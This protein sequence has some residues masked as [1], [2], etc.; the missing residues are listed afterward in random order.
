MNES[1]VHTLVGAYALDAVDDLERARFDRHLAE[2][3]ACA[4]EVM[5][6]R[7]AAGRLADLTVEAPPARLKDAVLA[8]VSRTRQVG[9]ARR[10][11]AGR[12]SRWRR[13]AV[14]AA[15]VA[16][17]GVGAGAGTYAVEE[18]RVRRAEQAEQV[19]AVLSAPDAVVRST[20][21][22]GGKMTVVLSSSLNAG[23][24]VVSGL[25]SPGA[26]KAYQLWV[27]KGGHPDSAGVLPAGA[28]SGTV[29][30]RN[31]VRDAGAMAISREPAGGSPQPTDPIKQIPVV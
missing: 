30:I 13:R 29:L 15:I 22:N 14:A 2:C 8:E 26:G 7:E 4:Q 16:V 28:G 6:L 10:T 20:D 12:D 24:A 9:P 3:E 17:I 11:A 23:V 18:Q 27:V 5:E 25:P 19:A 21:V 31:G 1:E